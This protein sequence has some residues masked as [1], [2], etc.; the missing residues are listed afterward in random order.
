MRLILFSVLLIYT[1][2]FA[3]EPPKTFKVPVSNSIEIDGSIQ[4]WKAIPYLSQNFGINLKPPYTDVM[5]IKM[6][7]DKEALYLLLN[8]K[9]HVG[10]IKNEA[11]LKIVFDIDNNKKTGSDENLRLNKYVKAPG[12][13]YVI[14]FKLNNKAVPY[15]DIYDISKK[16]QNPRQVI[17]YSA[18]SAM[19]ASTGNYMEIKIP[20]KHILKDEHTISRII[21]SEVGQQNDW[22]NPKSYLKKSIDF[23]DRNKKDVVSIEEKLELEE[24]L[25]DGSSV[26]WIVIFGFGLALMWPAMAICQKAGFPTSRAALCLIPAIGPFIFMWGICFNEWKLHSIFCANEEDSEDE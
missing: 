22:K 20:F 24:K 4:E 18:D 14:P 9:N 19:N 5:S 21:F 15:Y 26:G 8:T 12:F 2:C 13:E 7:M 23:S 11:F 3:Q 1:T 10:A 17:S 25:N 16:G 6:A